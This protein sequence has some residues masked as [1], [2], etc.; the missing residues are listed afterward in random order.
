MKK[1]L[2][3]SLLALVA[4]FACVAP[5]RAY[6]LYEVTGPVSA[7]CYGG[8]Y[9]L[10]G[11]TYQIYAACDVYGVWTGLP[12]NITPQKFVAFVTSLSGVTSEECVIPATF[13][14][15]NIAFAI[16]RTVINDVN[17]FKYVYTTNPN[18]GTPGTGGSKA[19]QLSSTVEVW[20]FSSK[21]EGRSYGYYSN[22]NIKTL[23]FEGDIRYQ[24]LPVYTYDD[25][26]S[27]AYMQ[28]DPST[29]YQYFYKETSTP[30]GTY[31]FTGTNKFRLPNLETLYLH[32][33]TGYG[34]AS[35][36]NFPA[37]KDVY[38]TSTTPYH[39]DTPQF[40][41]VDAVTAHLTNSAFAGYVPD[42]TYGYFHNFKRVLPES[43]D[44]V[45]TLDGGASLSLEGTT[46]GEG[47]RTVTVPTPD[48]LTFSIYDASAYTRVSVNGKRVN[49]DMT[50]GDEAFNGKAG[51]VY[52]TSALQPT[53]Y[54]HCLAEGD[55][56][57]QFADNAVHTLCVA[58]WDANGDGYLSKKEAAN[59]TSLGEVFKGNATIT[60]FP[61]LQYFTQLTTLNDSAFYG[62]TALADVTLPKTMKTI[63]QN[64][65][66]NTAIT[67]IDLPDGLTAIGTYTF[68]GCK[69]LET[70]DIPSGV[71]TLPALC[72]EVCTGLKH[73]YIP[74]TCARL[75]QF[76]FGGCTGLS[77]IVV[78][79]GNPMLSS[80][81]GCNAIV[82]NDTILMVGCKNSSIPEGIKGIYNF[83]FRDM[84]DLTSIELPASLTT[85]SPRA[86]LN[87]TGLVS[88]VSHVRAPFAFGTSAFANISSSCVLTVPYGTRQAYIDAGWTEAV[89]KGG[90]VEMPLDCDV[91]QD[92]TVSIAD[93]TTVVNN[94][95]DK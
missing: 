67:K 87:C 62:C 66:R 17:N 28:E 54:I 93:V 6:T 18:F 53:M 16:G 89:F 29:R 25:E 24:E 23:R 41:S 7:V 14:D 58:N 83:A 19:H 52:A 79:E 45:L 30:E 69:N 26:T 12:D 59:V 39:A 46:Y 44:V 64:A 37:L 1:K 77:S 34:A 60:S 27:V 65:F 38:F 33:L 82:L 51:W 75:F 31:K 61:E 78:E 68:G 49:E 84:A 55:Q 36:Y 91:N 90:V 80:P 88:V 56:V 57:I 72:F 95:L 15:T 35:L 86:F 50:Y 9:T 70:I 22:S 40:T 47:E 71:Q 13:E 8:T 42:D 94:I 5:G 92:G 48:G 76:P 32:T 10:N 73:L 2:I 20:G 74:K 43:V 4:T 11:V 85:I 3:T 63:G 81:K 21:F